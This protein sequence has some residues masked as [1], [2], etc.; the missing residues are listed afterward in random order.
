MTNIVFPEDN[1]I[2]MKNLAGIITSAKDNEVSIR[3]DPRWVKNLLCLIVDYILDW[4]LDTKEMSIEFL[5]E[6]G[7]E[8]EEAHALMRSLVDMASDAEM[9]KIERWEKKRLET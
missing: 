4:N 6:S 3:V 9:R 7:F 2:D 5:K 8:E 1:T